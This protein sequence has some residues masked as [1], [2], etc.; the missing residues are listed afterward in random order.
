MCQRTLG[1]NPVLA[2]DLLVISSVFLSLTAISLGRLSRVLSSVA[3]LTIS[4]SEVST[5]N[6]I[7]TS[8][9]TVSSLKT[10]HHKTRRFHCREVVFKVR[11]TLIP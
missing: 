3:E 11:L 9:K 10:D 6:E 1:F 4:C 5:G 2:L 8:T 7:S